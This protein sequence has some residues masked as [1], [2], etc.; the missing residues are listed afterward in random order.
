MTKIHT[1]AAAVALSLAAISVQAADIQMY[2]RVD[3]GLRYTNYHDSSKDDSFGLQAGNGE[4]Q[5]N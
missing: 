3:A 4:T 1:L 5:R 2:G